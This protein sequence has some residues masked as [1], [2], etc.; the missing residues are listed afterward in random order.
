LLAGVLAVGLAT[1]STFALFA[2]NILL[3]GG[4]VTG[5]D[6]QVSLGTATW[7]QVTPGVTTRASGTLADPTT[8]FASMPGDVVEIR[9]PFETLLQG[10]N[11]V[12]DMTVFYD[13]AAEAAGRIAA[14][15]RVENSSGTVV[16]P[17]TGGQ[18]ANTPL[19]L[20]GLTGT[21]AGAR[22]SWTAVVTVEVVG[23]YVWVTPSS[24]GEPVTWNPGTV[25]V[26]LAQA[27]DGGT[28]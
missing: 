4:T 8:A 24:P 11:L 21:D 2:A 12:A 28:P 19:T 9:I 7:Q 27:Q 20:T 5:G 15:F 17:A 26:M 22:A 25:R 18:D 6:L 3:T 16:A 14:T 23:D 10:D 1:G 13:S